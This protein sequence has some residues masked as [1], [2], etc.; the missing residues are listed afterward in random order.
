MSDNGPTKPLPKLE[1]DECKKPMRVLTFTPASNGLW[2]LSY[3][4]DQ[5]GR[6]TGVVHKP[7]D[8]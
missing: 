8:R 6:I 1:C 4:C 3:K 7:E 5:C 2:D